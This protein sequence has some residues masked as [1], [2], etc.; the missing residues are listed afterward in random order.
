MVGDSYALGASTDLTFPA[1]YPGASVYMIPSAPSFAAMAEPTGIYAEAG[2]GLSPGG[3]FARL[4]YLATGRPQILIN[5][6]KGA[7]RSDEWTSG[8]YIT[9]A[10]AQA[11]WVK[12]HGFTLKGIII[13]QGANNAIQELGDWDVDWTSAAATLRAGISGAAAVPIAY[14]RLQVTPAPQASATAK[15]A[16][17]A[18]TRVDQASWAAADRVMFD[19]PDSPGEADSLHHTSVQN[20]DMGGRALAVMAPLVP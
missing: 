5:A 3:A 9:K 12:H 17:W 6:A 18:A 1:G 8:A 13:I 11:N 4:R 15:A 19:V 7:T 16:Y 10:I 14:G 20:L 2:V